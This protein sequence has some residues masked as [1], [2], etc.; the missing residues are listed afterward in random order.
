MNIQHVLWPIL[1][2]SLL[3]TACND[4]NS[5][6]ESS[7]SSDGF[8]NQVQRILEAP[9]HD[10]EPEAVDNLQPDAEDRTTAAILNI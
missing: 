1:A 7:S 3:L 8:A 6:M 4:G 5:G 2:A 9:S 10:G